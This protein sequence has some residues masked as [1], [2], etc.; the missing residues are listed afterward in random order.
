VY[1]SGNLLGPTLF[2][3]C[4]NDIP[5]VEN[6]SNMTISVCADDTNITARSGSRD[7]AVRKLNAALGL[8]EAWFRKW[9]KGLYNYT[10]SQKIASLSPQYAPS[11]D[12]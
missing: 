6:N 7:L 3:V 12:F 1:L 8:L 10:L 5:S 2:N 4:I 9:G 11:K